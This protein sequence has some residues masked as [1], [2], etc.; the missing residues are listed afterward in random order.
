[1]TTAIAGTECPRCLGSM[2]PEND[3]FGEYMNCL[4]C[5]HTED[6]M[7]LAAMEDFA[8]ELSRNAAVP[9]RHRR[10]Q[11]PSRNGRRL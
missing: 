4:R 11:T 7:A 2:F 3:W 10:A 5:G 6:D 9:G 8:Q 1:M